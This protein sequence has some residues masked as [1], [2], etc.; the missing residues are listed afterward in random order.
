MMSDDPTAHPVIQA[1]AGMTGESAGGGRN[2]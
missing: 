1:C 2:R